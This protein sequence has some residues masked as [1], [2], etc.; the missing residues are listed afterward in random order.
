MAR[1]WVDVTLI[2]QGF[3]VLYEGY[4]MEGFTRTDGFGRPL[5]LP[6]S[7]GTLPP[8]ERAIFFIP[9]SL[10]WREAIAV[11]GAGERLL[12]PQAALVFKLPPLVSGISRILFDPTDIHAPGF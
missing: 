9:I 10:P 2:R 1:C 3:P 8:K 5:A 7:S 6:P 12:R 4:C 11:W